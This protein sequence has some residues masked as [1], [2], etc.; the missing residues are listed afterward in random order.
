MS[1]TITVWRPG[2]ADVSIRPGWFWHPAEDAAVRTVDDLMDLYFSSVGRNAK[3]LLN[4]PPTR[5]GVIHPTDEAR[6]RGMREQLEAT[7]AED[8]YPA[9]AAGRPVT[10]STADL[11]EDIARGQSVAAY[12]LE[13]RVEGAWQVLSRGTTIGHR[14]L[15]RVA[16]VAITGAR[17][18][19][20]GAVGPGATASAR[21][22]A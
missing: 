9:S 21:L 14:K 11:R 15:D 13:G 20:E 5:D 6:L 19:I 18:T 7:F 17:L 4:V 12:R 2:E 8:L 16:P 1:C 10:V 22:F 3:L